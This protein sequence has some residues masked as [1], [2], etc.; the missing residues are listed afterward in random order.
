MHVVY[1]TD[2]SYSPDVEIDHEGKVVFA[3]D[4]PSGEPIRIPV[5][6]LGRAVKRGAEDRKPG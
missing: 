1:S 4:I 2:A 6:M 3:R 5:H